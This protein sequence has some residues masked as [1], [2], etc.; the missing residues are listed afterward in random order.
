MVPHSWIAWL[1]F[2]WLGFLT[3]AYVWLF[4][5]RRGKRRAI[6]AGEATVAA[7]QARLAG[8]D[9]Q[10]GNLTRALALLGPTAS[11]RSVP[12][13]VPVE[14]AEDTRSSVE[15]PLRPLPSRGGRAAMPGGLALA[16]PVPR[17]SERTPTRVE[18]IEEAAARTRH[19]CG[20][21]PCSAWGCRC[22][23][24]GCITGRGDR[25]P[26]GRQ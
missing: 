19:H 17:I 8:Q 9:E 21:A 7:L 1:T 25:P 14:M 6:A 24:D 22:P 4:I 15:A 5:D 10:I 12:Q 26:P 20:K 13:L 11:S 23:C 16:L 3:F 2:S 18:T